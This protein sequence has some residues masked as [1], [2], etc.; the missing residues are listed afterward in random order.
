MPHANQPNELKEQEVKQKEVDKAGEVQVQVTTKETA[1]Q[2][3]EGLKE[4]VA[5][6]KKADRVQGVKGMPWKP[7][8]KKSNCLKTDRGRT[9]LT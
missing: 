4:E 7:H 2:S 6:Q 3:I 8:P 1:H 9:S 5:K